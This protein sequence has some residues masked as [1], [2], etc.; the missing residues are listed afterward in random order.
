MNKDIQQLFKNERGNIALFVIGMLGLMM[1]L[2][3]FVLNMGAALVVKEKSA[4]TAKQASMAATSM[5]YKEVRQEIYEYEHETLEGSIH[6]FFEDF[7]EKISDEK[8]SLRN[9]SNYNDWTDN[10]L[11]LEALDRVLDKALS[12]SELRIKLRE[13]LQNIDFDATVINMARNTI[14]ENGGKLEGATLTVKQNRIYVRAANE[15]EST[16]Y[17]GLLRGIKEKLYQESAG[18]KVDFLQDIWN[19]GTIQLN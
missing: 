14:V 10:E 19:P 16:S 3:V 2:F 8:D 13:I 1:V 11:E 12:N 4:T 5:L 18:P 15:V 7:D 6:A 17:D 9:N